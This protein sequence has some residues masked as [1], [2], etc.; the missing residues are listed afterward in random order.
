MHVDHASAGME[1]QEATPPAVVLAV[2]TLF[3]IA[4]IHAV[5]FPDIQSLFLC[6]AD[7]EKRLPVFGSFVSRLSIVHLPDCRK[8]WKRVNF[9]YTFTNVHAGSVSG[10]V[11]HRRA[12]SIVCIPRPGV[13][14]LDRLRV[15]ATVNA[16]SSIPWPG[17]ISTGV[18]RNHIEDVEA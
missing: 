2:P 1:V 17:F 6:V 16:I 8:Y 10:E 13:K 11:K 14:H 5:F 9:T 4:S 7:V 12:S 3:T 18:H 15:F